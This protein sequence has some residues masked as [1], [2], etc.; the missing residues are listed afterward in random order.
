MSSESIP[1][2]K[3]KRAL[4]APTEILCSMKREESK[5][6][7]NPEITYSSPISTV[8]YNYTIVNKYFA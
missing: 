2:S 7:P 8:I 6:P 5:L 4:E 1:P 3:P